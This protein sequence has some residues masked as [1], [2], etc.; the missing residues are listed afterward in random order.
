MLH[1]TFLSNV[2]QRYIGLILCI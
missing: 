2:T 1:D